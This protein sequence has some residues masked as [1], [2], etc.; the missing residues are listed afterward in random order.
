MSQKW[1]ENSWSLSNSVLLEGKAIEETTSKLRKWGKIWMSQAEC[2]GVSQQSSR[3]KNNKAPNVGLWADTG[4]CTE[5]YI[6]LSLGNAE[7]HP[8]RPQHPAL[9]APFADCFFTAINIGLSL[10]FPPTCIK[11]KNLLHEG[12]SRRTLLWL[13]PEEKGL[14]SQ[15]CNYVHLAHTEGT[16]QRHVSSLRKSP[17]ICW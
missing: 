7:C 16:T 5:E 8:H 17:D 13:L 11:L 15:S 9:L 6:A 2:G 14:P 3:F 10:Y 12:Y 1:Q 4:C